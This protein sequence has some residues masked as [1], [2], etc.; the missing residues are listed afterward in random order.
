MADALSLRFD[1]TVLRAYAL[2][3]RTYALR[4]GVSKG[5]STHTYL[6]GLSLGRTKENL[7]IYMEALLFWAD[8]WYDSLEI[9]VDVPVIV[10]PMTRVHILQHYRRGGHFMSSIHMIPITPNMIWSRIP[11]RDPESHKGTYGNVLTVCGCEEYRGAAALCTMGALRSGAGLVTLAASETVISSVAGQVLEATFLPLPD[12]AALV[13]RVRRARVCAAG[14]GKKEIPD[15]VREMKL[16]LENATGTVV[17][18]AGGLCSLATQTLETDAVD[19]DG[20]TADISAGTIDVS[21]NTA[22]AL[23]SSCSGRLIITPHPGEMAKLTCLSVEQIRQMPADVALGYAKKTGAVVVLKGHRTIIASPDGQVY[24]NR[25]GNAGLARGGSGD[26]LTGIIAG[27]AAQGL[28]PLDAALC[29]VWL[30]GTAA[31]RC[32]LRKSMMG[33]LPS[34][35]LE[36][37]GQIFLE[38]GY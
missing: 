15:T 9:T 27:L 12:E 29:G 23:L 19:P 21:V 4:T 36:D 28:A 26:V 11:K 5:L 22:A 31:D 2:L 10:Y 30:H 16:I 24:E 17:L 1:A 37:L 32:A 25:T 13:E 34:D 20:T 18:D 35:I 7:T 33:M 8:L 6:L 3:R 38:N 14:C